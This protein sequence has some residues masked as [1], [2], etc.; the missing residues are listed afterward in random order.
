MT[1]T[2][3][4]VI[5]DQAAASP[6]D[7]SALPSADLR[8]VEGPLTRSTIGVIGER[9]STPA[10]TAAAE[11]PAA[12][13]RPG[14]TPLTGTAPASGNAAETDG[15]AAEVADTPPKTEPTSPAPRS[16]TSHVSSR[17]A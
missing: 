11:K 12:Q 1:I 2:L 14:S 13:P 17:S 5:T 4:P 7:G 10:G 6:A 15:T 9:A 8:L 16:R 3:T